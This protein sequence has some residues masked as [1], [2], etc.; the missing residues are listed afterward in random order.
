[1]HFNRSQLRWSRKTLFNTVKG[2]IMMRPMLSIL[3]LLC[4]DV[5]RK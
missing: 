3:L 2:K 1:M 5:Q 4:Y